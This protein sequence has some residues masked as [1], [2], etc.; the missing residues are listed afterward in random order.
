VREYVERAGDPQVRED[1]RAGMIALV[2]AKSVGGSKSAKLADFVLDDPF[3]PAETETTAADAQAAIEQA[4]VR[5][6]AQRVARVRRAEREA[7]R[8]QLKP[9]P[10]PKVFKRKAGRHG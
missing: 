10:A 1:V 6:E 7:R 5:M 2:V 9:P 8:R 3:A 4:F